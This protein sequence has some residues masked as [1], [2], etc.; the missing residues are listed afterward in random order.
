MAIWSL[1]AR[2][3]IPVDSDP[4]AHGVVFIDGSQIVAV[5]PY[6]GQKPTL[7][8]GRVAILPGLVN[9]HV[10]LDLGILKGKIS[11]PISFS[12]WLAEI[13][14]HRREQDPA[15]LNAVISQ[16]M[17]ESLRSGVTA[18]GD[19]SSGGASWQSLTGA[20]LRS[21]VF[22]ELLG[23]PADRA[24]MAWED[25]THWLQCLPRTARCRPGFSPHAPYSVRA[26]LT[27]RVAKAG[28]PW[29]IHFAESYEETELLENHSGPL[30][31][32]LQ[33]LNVWDDKGLAK[34]H[35][36]I[37]DLCQ[38]GD[39]PLLIH[40][41]HWD[42]RNELPAGVT[43]VHC[44]RTHAYFGRPKF[45][46][47]DFLKALVRVALG[48]DSLASNPDLN[49]LSDLRH[50]ARMQPEVS[51]PELVRVATLNGAQALGLGNQCG[52]L[53]AGKSADLVVVPYPPGEV[54]D[55]YCGILGSDEQVAAVLFEG[56][57]VYVRDA[58]N[59]AIPKAA[60][61]G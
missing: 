48:T 57:W 59:S 28:Q 42:P 49:L 6:A 40:A 54:G 60:L 16:G 55:P 27:E 36:A 1:T 41:N 61:P 39:S 45:P 53:T 34:T 18:L 14:R 9:A 21:L 35:Q 8:L 33:S 13:V 43:V 29:C 47:A 5:E 51:P 30:R 31:A 2:Y 56:R 17:M 7:D 11:P 46:L 10:H 4:L 22:Y 58:G 24:Q 26:S 19:I 50:L 32:F 3:V 20:T 52:S 25:A 37:L 44:P 38:F 12:A 15:L 23:L